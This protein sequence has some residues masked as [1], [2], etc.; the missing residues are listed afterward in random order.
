MACNPSLF[1][2]LY[3]SK[4][5]LDKTEQERL[6][7]LTPEAPFG[8]LPGVIDLIPGRTLNKICVGRIDEYDNIF[9][10]QWCWGVAVES[11]L[12]CSLFFSPI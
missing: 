8:D 9:C 4:E 2:S 6:K 1:F 7:S 5:A 12:Q 3:G 10:A 11:E